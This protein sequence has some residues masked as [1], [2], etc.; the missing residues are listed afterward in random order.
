MSDLFTQSVSAIKKF[1]Q[2]KGYKLGWRFLNGS[3]KTLDS[4]PAVALITANP[5][6]GVIPADHPWESC[7]NGSSYLYESWGTAAPGKGNLQ[8]QIQ[9]L[10]DKI[11][12]HGGLSISRNELI[13]QSLT[14]YFIPFRSPRLDDLE[15]KQEAYQFGYDLWKNILRQVHPKLFVCIDKETHKGLKSLISEVYG[16]TLK[17]SRKVDTGWGSYTGDIDI[18]GDKSEIIMIRLP[19]LSTFKLFTSAKCRDQV[20]AIFHEACVPLRK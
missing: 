5:G 9:L 11:I 4:N 6:G 16:T 17:E 7:E 1:Y 20:N 3:K 10:F 8:I 19:H 18:F 14:G 13:E 15:H 12:E 2:E